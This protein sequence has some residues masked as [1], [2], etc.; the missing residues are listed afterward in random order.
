M[1]RR[2]V[3][4]RGRPEVELPPQ[5][6]R[7]KLVCPHCQAVN[8]VLTRDALNAPALKCSNCERRLA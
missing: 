5:P 4:R 7:V 3:P 1:N 6:K 2:P 8:M